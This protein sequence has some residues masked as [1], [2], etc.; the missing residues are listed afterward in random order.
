MNIQDLF[1][2]FEGIL[3]AHKLGVNENWKRLIPV[4]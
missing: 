1:Y 4:L 3:E 2:H